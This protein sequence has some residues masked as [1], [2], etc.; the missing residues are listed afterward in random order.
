MAGSA[1]CS[2][3]WLGPN[4]A[5][6]QSVSSRAASLAGSRPDPDTAQLLGLKELHPVWLPNP[7]DLSSS[8]QNPSLLDSVESECALQRTCSLWVL[9]HSS[10]P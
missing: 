1:G 6:F 2:G 8:S 7:R 4:L 10:A 3:L 5:T 9:E